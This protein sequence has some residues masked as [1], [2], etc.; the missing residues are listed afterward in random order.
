MTEGRGAGSPGERALVGRRFCPLKRRARRATGGGMGER[1][2]SAGSLT[3]SSRLTKARKLTRAPFRGRNLPKAGEETERSQPPRSARL[4]ASPP[5]RTPFVS[6]RK[7]RNTQNHVSRIQRQSEPN[8][9][10]ARAV[11]LAPLC[12]V[13]WSAR[14]NLGRATS[15]SAFQFRVHRISSATLSDYLSHLHCIPEPI[16]RSPACPG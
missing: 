14:S 4:K 11:G 13:C 3:R 2:T 1:S 9:T 16:D 7:R 15:C 5:I 8:G 6:H 12:A 10:R